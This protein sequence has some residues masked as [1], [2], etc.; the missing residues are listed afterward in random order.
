M[1]GLDGLISMGIGMGVLEA[2]P[3]EPTDNPQISVYRENASPVYLP[4]F[5]VPCIRSSWI[6]HRP[7]K[8]MERE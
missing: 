2:D 4:Q 8:G 7:A 6:L 3:D 1:R 5:V